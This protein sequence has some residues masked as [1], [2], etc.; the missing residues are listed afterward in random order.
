MR[1]RLVTSA[2]R[3]GA[4]GPGPR[5]SALPGVGAYTA[6]AVATFAFGQRHPVVDTNV[7]RLV[8]R[9]RAGRPDGG[10]ATTA[11]D[12]AQVADLLPAAAARAAGR[13]WP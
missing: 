9:A 8:A 7:R 5:C 11:S 4:P 10:A 3:R 2:R 1:D 12:L 13:A 6:R